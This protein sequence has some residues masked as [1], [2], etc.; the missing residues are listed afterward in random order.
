MQTSPPLF[1]R[2]SNRKINFVV[3]DNRLHGIRPTQV[4]ADTDYLQALISKFPIEFIQGRQ[5]FDAGYAPGCHK[6]HHQMILLIP[7][8]SVQFW[9]L[10]F[11]YAAGS[12][13]ITE[14]GAGNQHT[15][16]H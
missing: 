9:F 14:T 11:P 7:D 12:G 2:T 6:N 3:V 5:F 13:D 10:D 16:N 1:R 4:D 15:Q 8:F